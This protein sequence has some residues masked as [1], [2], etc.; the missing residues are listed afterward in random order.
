MRAH[1]LQ[2]R[3]D[4][5]LSCTFFGYNSLE[6]FIAK[7]GLQGQAWAL[8][9]SS[10]ALSRTWAW[11]G[12]GFLG[13][14]LAGLGLSGLAHPSLQMTLCPKFLGMSQVTTQVSETKI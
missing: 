7:P 9:I 12:L 13:L 4:N 5:G 3:R 6:I 11:L 14:G 1:M 8:K 2:L 10:Q